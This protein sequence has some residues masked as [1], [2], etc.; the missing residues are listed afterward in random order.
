MSSSQ[1]QSLLASM[2]DKYVT[3]NPSSQTAHSQAKDVLAGGNTRAILHGDP[4]PLYVESGR[5]SCIRSVDGKEYLDLVSDFSA[6]F[7]G[8]SHPVITDAISQAAGRGFSLGAVTQSEAKLGHRIRARF[9]SMEKLRFCNSG[10]EANT[11]ALAT[12]MAFTGRSKVGS[13]HLQTPPV[14]STAYNDGVRA[15]M[16]LFRS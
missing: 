2:I 10:T 9:P 15:E 6:A 12:A 3:E 11:F 4:F 5:G 7:L 1:A 8:H 16:N 13:C 14:E